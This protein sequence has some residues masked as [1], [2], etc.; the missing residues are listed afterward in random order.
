[1]KRKKLVGRM[2]HNYDTIKYDLAK[3]R[4]ELAQALVQVDQYAKMIGGLNERCVD[5]G[6]QVK[7]WEQ[8]V[9]LLE[10]RRVL[11]AEI[12]LGEHDDLLERGT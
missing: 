10:R 6:S 4:A 2:T 1:M 9:S 3:A 8:R 7:R 12:L 5:L 11:A